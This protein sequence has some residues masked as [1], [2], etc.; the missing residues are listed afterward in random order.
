MDDSYTLDEVSILA[1][2]AVGQP[3]KRT[4]FLSL[5]QN[6]TW[7][8]L[9]VEKEELRALAMAIRQFLFALSQEEPRLPSSALAGA[10]PS[11]TGS[12][13]PSAE[14]EIE[15]ITLGYEDG[16]AVLEVGAHRSGRRSADKVTLRGLLTL[17]QLRHLGNQADRVCAAGRPRC[18]VCGQPIDPSGHVCPGEN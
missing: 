18:P 10:S 12:G 11:E 9:W 16:K 1:A 17:G 2:V 5:G 15:E 13:L 3:G 7:F 14:L 4:F 6:G 8:R